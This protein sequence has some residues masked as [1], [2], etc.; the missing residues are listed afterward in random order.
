MKSVPL[1]INR[2]RLIPTRR[3]MMK[4]LRILK[5]M[6]L[7]IKDKTLFIIKSLHSTVRITSNSIRKSH[8]KKAMARKNC[9]L[10]ALKRRKNH[11]IKKSMIK[12]TSLYKVVKLRSMSKRRTRRRNRRKMAR[13][14]IGM[15]KKCSKWRS[16]SIM[17]KK[18]LISKEIKD[19]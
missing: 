7:S 19:Q 8:K 12:T 10:N 16:K 13:K 15:R 3:C 14:N 2:W 9:L 17:M 18:L 1:M 5:P 6:L 4:N 11:A